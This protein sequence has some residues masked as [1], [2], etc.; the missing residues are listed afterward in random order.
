[1]NAAIEYIEINLTSEIDI[2]RA[3]DKAFCSPYHFQRMFCAI[4]GLTPAEYVR[5]R[6]LTLAAR[7]L[8]SSQSKVIDIAVKYGYDSPVSFGRAFRNFHGITPQ[9]ARASG[10]KLTAFPKIKFSVILSGGND[11]D[12]KIVEK[13][14]FSLTGKSRRF[15]TLQGEN[16]IKIPQYWQEFMA[17]RDFTTLMN[18]NSEKPGTVTGGTCLGLISCLEANNWDT[19]IYSIC[20]EK[21]AG[22]NSGYEVFDIPAATWAVFDCSLSNIQTVT[23]RIFSEWFPSTGYEHDNIPEIE[24]YFPE[25]TESREIQCQIWIP[26]IH[27]K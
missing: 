4:T 12:Y 11:M 24:V 23:K 2:S 6:R 17:S 18:L 21:P 7:E 5:R 27:Q 26:V 1:M 13:P 10:V 20:V 15:S 16:F 3:A 9:A 22:V 8:A 25:R 14:E 19:V